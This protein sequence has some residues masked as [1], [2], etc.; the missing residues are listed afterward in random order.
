MYNKVDIKNVAEKAGISTATVSRVL[1][2]YPGVRDKTRKRVLETIKHLYYE[3]NI[4]ARDLRQK[5]THN[6]GIIVGNVLSQFY[7]TIAKAV[8]DVAQK[9]GYNMILCNSDDSPEKELEYLKVLSSNKIA[10]I[11]LTPTGKNVDYIKK[12]IY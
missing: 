7:S 4:L 1:H 2:N 11:N 6:I 10:G 8:E 5:K 12:G 9:E 3:V